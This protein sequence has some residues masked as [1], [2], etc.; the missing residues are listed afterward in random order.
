MAVATSAHRVNQVVVLQ[1]RCPVHAG[2]LRSLIRM[3]QNLFLW[4]SP[5]D[6]HQQRLQHDI[7]CLSAL[8]GPANDPAG[9]KID[10][11]REIGEAFVGTDVGYVGDPGL[12]RGRDVELPIQSVV[13]DNGRPAAINTRTAFVS[14]LSLYPGNP[15]QAGNPVGAGCLPVIEQVVVKLTVTL[16]LATFLPGFPQKTD[17]PFV[18]TSPLAQGHPE[19]GV[20]ATGMDTQQTA[21]RPHRKQLLMLCNERVLHFASLAKYAV[22]F[23]NMSR[24]SVTRASSFLSCLISLA[25]SLP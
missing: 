21:H 5:P 19:P 4:L 20:K 9:I 14:D 7:G 17:L 12:V 2:E 8:H 22:A 3:H 13:D 10:H 11:H 23:F 24:S 16:D 25:W 6:S 1:E 15:C 18:F